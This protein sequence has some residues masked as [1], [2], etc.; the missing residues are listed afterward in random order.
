M[1]TH[2]YTLKFSI[3]THSCQ[4]ELYLVPSPRVGEGKDGGTFP[5]GL[6][7]PGVHKADRNYR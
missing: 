1:D 6:I 4:I 7:I 3:V 2:Y 5:R